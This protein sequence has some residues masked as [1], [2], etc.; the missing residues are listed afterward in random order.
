M[1]FFSTT[2]NIAFPSYVC[3]T[4]NIIFQRQPKLSWWVELIRDKVQL[5]DLSFIQLI[6]YAFLEVPK[7]TCPSFPPSFWLRYFITI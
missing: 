5:L 6:G 7:N 4:I 2:H 3:L 1:Q